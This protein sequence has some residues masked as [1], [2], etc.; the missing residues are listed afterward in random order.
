MVTSY[1]L[2]ERESNDQHRLVHKFTY[3]P[4]TLQKFNPQP[5]FYTRALTSIIV[6]ARKF[7]EF[8]YMPLEA[9][10]NIK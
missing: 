4:Y 9:I 2:R 10:S 6:V 8:L 7:L 1:I 3:D 5:Y